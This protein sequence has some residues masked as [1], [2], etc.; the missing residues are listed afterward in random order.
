MCSKEYQIQGV[1]T[2]KNE[3]SIGRKKMYQIGDGF[4]VAWI[5]CLRFIQGNPARFWFGSH[6]ARTRFVL[7]SVAARAWQPSCSYRICA[8]QCRCQRLAA[9]L[10]VQDLC[11]TVS[12][13]E[14]GLEGCSLIYWILTLAILSFHGDPPR[15][16][17]NICLTRVNVLDPSS[18]SHLS[19]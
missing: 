8:S 11:F 16:I 3:M 19:M 14:K 10:L 1:S 15:G 13:S 5:P 7:R 17:Y 2:G 9:I 18:S 12:L 4:P 6:L